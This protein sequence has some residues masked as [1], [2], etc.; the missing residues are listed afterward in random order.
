MPAHTTSRRT[1]F[2][3][4]E[5]LVSIAI[6]A[7]LVS[8]LLPSLAHA[9][10]AA[11][12][13]RELA[14]AQQQ[15][16]AFTLYANEHAGR[17]L[18]GLLPAQ[19]AAGIN[20]LGER[21]SGPAAQRYPWRL[22]PQYD[23]DFN[24]LYYSDKALRDLRNEPTSYQ[25]LVSL[26]PLLGMNTQFV[27]GDARYFGFDNRFARF[28]GKFYI[29]RIDQPL[30]PSQLL[31]FVS[32][33]PS[34]QALAGVAIDDN[35]PG[36][37]HVLAP[38]FADPSPTQWADRYEP[39]TEAPGNNSGFVALRHSGKA[40][41]AT[42]DGHAELLGWEQLRDMRRWANGATHADWSLEPR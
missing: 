18:P 16:L 15:M 34:P 2:T 39:Q 31:V 13:T 1:A 17:V 33:R 4:I 6:I 12:Q 7:L 38:R 9:R 27:G 41:G 3:L 36:Y 24:G 32:A 5:V 35:L 21:F 40:V 14:A 42:F 28:F 37:H 10:S 22:A 30:R 26:F 20:Q 25:Y 11:R 23:Y 19:S 8:I 29:E